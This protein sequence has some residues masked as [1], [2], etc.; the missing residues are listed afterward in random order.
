MNKLFPTLEEQL[1]EGECAYALTVADITEL[2]D[3]KGYLPMAG[4]PISVHKNGVYIGQVITNNNGFANI[5]FYHVDSFEYGISISEGTYTFTLEL[6]EGFELVSEEISQTVRFVKTHTGRSI[7][8]PLSL[9][10]PFLIQRSSI[11]EVTGQVTERLMDGSIVTSESNRFE[12]K[13]YDTDD[14]PKQVTVNEDGSFKA[15]LPNGSYY[16]NIT[17]GMWETIYPFSVGTRKVHIAGLVLEDESRSLRNTTL[18]N[19]NVRKVNLSTTLDRDIAEV[20]PYFEGLRWTNMVAA[21]RETYQG[22][23]Y[24]N[25]AMNNFVLYNGS[26]FQSEIHSRNEEDFSILYLSVGGST[27][28]EDHKQDELILTT[29]NGEDIVTQD[30]IPLSAYYATDVH[31]L[32]GSISK[33]TFS[34]VNNWHVIIAEMYIS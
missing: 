34:S 9:T 11:V 7:Y 5:P 21:K 22:P 23:G 29:Y 1:P 14:V 12:L 8:E 30:T 16:I 13:I 25:V 27:M 26:G 31:L 2:M 28:F 20:P 18:P 24:N 4:M 6:P 17:S 32:S 10:Q 3:N 33:A 15:N 19:A